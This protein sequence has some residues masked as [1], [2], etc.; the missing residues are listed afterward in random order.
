MQQNA[1]LNFEPVGKVLKISGEIIP[2]TPD[3][4][5]VLVKLLDEANPPEVSVEFKTVN[6]IVTYSLVFKEKP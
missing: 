3:E 6:N 2:A 1:T 5:D 4:H